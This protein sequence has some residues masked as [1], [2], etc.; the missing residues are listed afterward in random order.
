MLKIIYLLTLIYI[1]DILKVLFIF[2]LFT[3]F[4]RNLFFFTVSIKTTFEHSG[5]SAKKGEML[6][7]CKDI[8]SKT[9]VYFHNWCTIVKANSNYKAKIKYKN[10]Y[11]FKYLSLILLHI[12]VNRFYNILNLKTPCRKALNCHMNNYFSKKKIYLAL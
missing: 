11:I 4:L 5:C 3:Y 8:N 9:T 6:T 2:N 10:N 1:K 7:T 12:K